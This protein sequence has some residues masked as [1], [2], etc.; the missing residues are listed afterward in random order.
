[1]AEVAGDGGTHLAVDRLTLRQILLTG[2]E[3]A[4]AFGKRFTRYRVGTDGGAVACFDDGAEAGGDVLVAAD[5]VNSPVRRQY[6]PHARVVDTGLRQLYGKVL[7][8]KETR[9]LFPPEMFAV[10]TPVIGPAKQFV[11]VAPMEFPSR[12]EWRPA[13]LRPRQR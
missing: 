11:G 10:F 6:L 5:G 8:T 1:M 4:V 3:D 13:G 12:L 9:A 7:L 2:V